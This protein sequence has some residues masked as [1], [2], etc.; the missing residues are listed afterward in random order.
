MW[1]RILPA[2]WLALA[3]GPLAA[4]QVAPVKV[5]K[6]PLSAID[7]L[8]RSVK[9]NPPGAQ[10]T[11][12]VLPLPIIVPTT[13]PPNNAVNALPGPG[14]SDAATTTGIEPSKIEVSPLQAIRKDTVGL[15]PASV[16]GLP[17]DFWGDSNIQ[18]IITLISKQPTDSLPEVLSL[19]YTILLAEVDAPKSTGPGSQLLL[20]RTDKLLDMGALDQAQA[21]L[22]RAGPTEAQIFRRWFDV[23]LLTGHEDHACTAMRAAPGFAPTL[24]AQV[25]CLARGGDW[26]AA[27][28]TL[29]TGETLGFIK[30][31]DADLM[32]RFLDPGMFEGAPDLPMPKPLTPLDFTMREA[33]GQPRPSGALPLAF[34]NADLAHNGPWRAQLEAA[35]RLVRSQALPPKRLI[36][37]YTER[38]PAASGGIWKRAAAIQAFDVAMLSGDQGAVQK[39]LPAA[40]G[41]MQEVA[42]E[43]PFALYY[44]ARLAEIKFNAPISKAASDTLFTVA[45]LSKGYETEARKVT[46]TTPKQAFVKGVAIGRLDGL[47]PLNPLETAIEA[48]FLQPMPNGPLF[49]LLQQGQLGEAILRAMLM[50]KNE[51]FADP[52]DIQTALATFR[53]V[54]LEGVARRVAIQL[55]LL[56][57][58]G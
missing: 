26:N 54:G 40:Y 12:P 34:L 37:L 36:E 44:G 58:R 4:Q 15:L 50:L 23:S 30:K 9:E 57:R 46:P 18:T 52:G 48:A 45:L 24:E 19:L 17:Q 5:P 38:K 49:D 39:T 47:K 20:A 14:G 29:A 3:S 33:I 35:E 6:A 25:F 53:A 41:A 21:L 7:W 51:A 2:I 27:A 42:L 13:E 56:E 43:V 28:V 55:L 31:P 8:S 16:T 10:T 1:I 22:E 11:P 32:T